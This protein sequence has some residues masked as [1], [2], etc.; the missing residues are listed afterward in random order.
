MDNY[1]YENANETE[2]ER[3]GVGY[4]T[5]RAFT[6]DEAIP[7]KGVM[8]TIID[9]SEER[10]VLY[11]LRTDRS[12]MT[13]TVEIAVP[14]KENSE[15]PNERKKYGTVSIEAKLTGYY[16]MTYAE[17]PIFDTVS[18]TQSVRMIPLSEDGTK[19][20]LNYD[21]GMLFDTKGN[22]L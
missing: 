18:A 2:N 15:S 9:E 17:V 5:V 13:E 3:S 22:T 10:R 20:I 16:T 7:L 14:P 4:L 19:Y 6:G 12:G 1:K 8:V 11:S 21:E